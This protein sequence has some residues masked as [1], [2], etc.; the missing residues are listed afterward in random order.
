VRLLLSLVVCFILWDSASY[1]IA[2]P[3]PGEKNPL[4]DVLAKIDPAE[5]EA[6]T[7][8]L[9]M[10]ATTGRVSNPRKGVGPTDHEQ[11]QIDANPAFSRAFARDPA[12]TL[13]VLREVN[14]DLD[15]KRKAQH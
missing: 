12:A 2:G 13:L 10:L 3:P 14:D 5:W 11:S 8:K 15:R 6:V 1:V 4:L 9:E 7:P